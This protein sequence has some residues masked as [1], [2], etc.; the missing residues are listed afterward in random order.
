MHDLLFGHLLGGQARPSALA[1]ASVLLQ[2]PNQRLDPSLL[3][4][5]DLLWLLLLLVA[6]ESGDL[7]AER[8]LAVSRRHFIRQRLDLVWDV[9][10]IVAWAG[11]IFLCLN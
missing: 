11:I 10:L 5:L 8:V 1:H 3:F 7:G 4:R 9:E 2:I 6:I